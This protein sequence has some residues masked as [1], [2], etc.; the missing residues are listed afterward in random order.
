MF[1]CDDYDDDTLRRAAQQAVVYDAGGVPL[2][3]TVPHHQP[4]ASM[5]ASFFKTARDSRPGIDT[6][7]FAAPLHDGSNAGLLTTRRGW[8]TPYGD[9][10]PDTETSERFIRELGAEINDS[11]LLR[12]HSISAVMPFA[13]AYFPDAAVAC[14][15][16]SGLENPDTARRIAALLAS[17]A[18][19]RDCLF[20]FSVDFSHFLPPEE[21]EICDEQ[22]RAAV[23][24]GDLASIA[25]MGNDNTDSPVCVSVFVQLTGLLGGQVREFDHGNS[26]LLSGLPPSHPAFAGGLTSYFVFM[27]IG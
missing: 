15:L 9:L 21:T 3:G 13:A 6:I 5:I 11:L 4:A 16:V 10:P 27:G 1:F 24:A 25:R 26:L 12:E 20:V 8:R 17:V 18:E 14:L 2:C 23:L 22:T 19:T 7:V